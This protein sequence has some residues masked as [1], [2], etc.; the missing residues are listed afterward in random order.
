MMP[1]FFVCPY[2]GSA[3]EC[4]A[5]RR[6]HILEKH[7][8]LASQNWDR[9]AET[10]AYPDMVYHSN[11]DG[12]GRGFAKWYDDL[13]KSTIDIAINEKDGRNWLITAYLSRK[14]PKGEILWARN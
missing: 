9:V 10:F 2:L 3:I 11:R 6:A 8:D 1:E 5:E 14:T 7:P 13:Q 4:T 12:R